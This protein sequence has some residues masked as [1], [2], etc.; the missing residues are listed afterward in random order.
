[1]YYLDTNT[2]IFFLNGKHPSI[3]SKLLSTSPREIAIPSLVK[4]ELILGANK[5]KQKEPNVERSEEHT[6]ELQ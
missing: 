1:M 5:S 3:R 2:C 4:A 6:S